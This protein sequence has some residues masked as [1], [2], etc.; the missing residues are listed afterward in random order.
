MRV[1]AGQAERELVGVRLAD[2]I[3]PGVEQPAHGGGVSRGGRRVIQERR[4]PR[5][6]R[7]PRD[8]DHVL[9]RKRDAA[10]R[11]T[12]PPAGEQLGADAER[13]DERIR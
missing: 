10:Q 11:A 5:P 2:H 6:G 4:V 9:D 12:R 7:D 13:V 3:R 8:V 1:R